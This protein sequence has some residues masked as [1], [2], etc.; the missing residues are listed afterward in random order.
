MQPPP[1]EHD[2]NHDLMPWRLAPRT[3]Q[4]RVHVDGDPVSR[5]QKALGCPKISGVLPFSAQK[6]MRLDMISARKLHDISSSFFVYYISLISA[7]TVSRHNPSDS[8]HQQVR[9][10][11]IK[12]GLLIN[13]LVEDFSPVEFTSV[14][15]GFEFILFFH[16][17]IMND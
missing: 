1:T 16:P 3:V 5:N 12:C 14:D 4:T 11:R 9:C 13:F 2:V 15:E 7:R 17:N 6:M 8:H 10:R